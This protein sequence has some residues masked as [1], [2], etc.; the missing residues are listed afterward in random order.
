MYVFQGTLSFLRIQE[1][2]QTIKKEKRIIIYPS[3]RVSIEQSSVFFR[4]PL[5][6]QGVQL[7]FHTL[8]LIRLL[9][10]GRLGRPLSQ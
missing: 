4:P 3:F 10:Q 6:L 8:N 5:L 7:R 1:Q 2:N 9:G